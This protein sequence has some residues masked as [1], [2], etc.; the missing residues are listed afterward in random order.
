MSNGFYLDKK[1][2]II[3]IHE[4]VPNLPEDDLK[5][6]LDILLDSIASA[7]KYGDH[8]IDIVFPERDKDRILYLISNKI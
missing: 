6:Y 2:K 5:I 1:G 7:K 8:T 4:G 3:I